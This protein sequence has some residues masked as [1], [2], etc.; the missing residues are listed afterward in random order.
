MNPFATAKSAG[1]SRSE[2]NA[3]RAIPRAKAPRKGR[4]PL[5]T[6]FRPEAA[7]KGG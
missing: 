7:C 3:K 6:A 1:T 2:E 5:K 4:M